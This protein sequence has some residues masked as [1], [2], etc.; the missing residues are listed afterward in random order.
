M[1]IFTWSV[2]KW[3]RVAR[4]EWMFQPVRC[5]FRRQE[6][7][8]IIYQGNREYFRSVLISGQ[9][10]KMFWWIDH[11]IVMFPIRFCGPYWH[12]CLSHLWCNDRTGTQNSFPRPWHWHWARL[13]R[14]WHLWHRD[15]SPMSRRHHRV[16]VKQTRVTKQSPQTR[17]NPPT[18]EMS[19]LSLSSLSPPPIAPSWQ[20]QKLFVLKRKVNFAP[21]VAGAA[22]YN[23]LSWRPAARVQVRDNC[24]N[25]LLLAPRPQTQPRVVFSNGGMSGQ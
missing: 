15:M 21:R 8:G 3:W 2:P 18:T 25:I 7:H 17:R 16:S 9:P 5:S 11:L 22:L 1:R 6:F 13:W 4:G 14:C 19:I 20:W 12:F 10:I 24:L 23:H